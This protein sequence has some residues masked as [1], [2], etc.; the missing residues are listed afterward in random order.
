MTVATTQKYPLA[1]D[2]WKQ[3]HLS[4]LKCSMLHGE[5]PGTEGEVVEHPQH[6]EEHGPSGEWKIFDE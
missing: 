1:L 4:W 6:E 2:T 3:F 5:E